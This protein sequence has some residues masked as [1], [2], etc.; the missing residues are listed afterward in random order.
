MLF[1]LEL[2]Q[3][4]DESQSKFLKRDNVQSIKGG[5]YKRIE[6]KGNIKWREESAY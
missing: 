3:I 1:K 4:I 2:I 6:S 5:D